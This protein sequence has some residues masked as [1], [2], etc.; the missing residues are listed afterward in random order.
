[1]AYKIVST[2][3]HITNAIIQFIA[4]ANPVTWVLLAITAAISA[5]VSAYTAYKL[6]E[7][8][9]IDGD[10]AKHFGN[11][12]LSME[13]IQNIA[14]YIVSS[15]SL[16]G[17]K[18]ALEAFED[19]D[20]LGS[21]M[22]DSIAKLD[23][24]N[25]KVSIG[26]QLTS[27]EQDEYK[28]TIDEYVSNAQEYVTQSRY[29]VSVSLQL[30]LDGSDPTSQSITD[31]V[32]K[33]YLDNYNQLVQLGKDL[34][35]AITDAFNDG[36]LEVD[37]ID[38]ITHLQQQMAN[39][40]KAIA[41]G[42]Y[43]AALA[44]IQNKYSGSNLD[45]ESFQN[46]QEELATQTADAKTAYEEAYKKNYAAVTASYKGGYLTEGEYKSA[47]ANL[48]TTLANDLAG[49]DL[50]AAQFQINS[51]MDN[52][53]TEIDTYTN[54]L[55]DTIAEFS[56]EQ[57]KY[58]WETQPAMMWDTVMN[59]VMENDSIS[60]ESRGAIEQ[61]LNNM[62]GTIERLNEYLTN[63]TLSADTKKAVEEAVA[64]L[65]VLQGYTARTGFFGTEGF[66]QG[67]SYD[68]GNMVLG[69]GGDAEN[70]MYKWVDE[71]F[72]KTSVYAHKRFVQ[73]G[74]TIN[75][76]LNITKPGVPYAST[77]ADGGLVR[78]MEL[79]WL[80]ERGPEMVVPL[81]GSRRAVS[82][83]QQAGQLLGMGGRFDNVSL[84]GDSA[85]AI[86]YSPTLQFYGDAP[87]RQELMMR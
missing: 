46:L 83:W 45:S 69:L 77:H 23:K 40:Q 25:W 6:E 33:F 59:A 34:N 24:M 75:P 2:I 68:L 32:D 5:V 60:D 65:N 28:A 47:V 8:E 74:V 15:D 63:P 14:S 36:L 57:Y 56:G 35:S 81:D 17:V 87:D 31:K 51:I 52:Y 76:N 48:D 11:I 37:E 13:D 78:S 49:V 20:E 10:L 66:I 39:I 61:L 43:D 54:V 86:T 79:S 62:S 27:D 73:E 12:K 38:T 42:E 44:L 3:V 82:L 55:K 84:G 67:L 80:A 16:G 58:Q 21:I 18:R 72:G 53:A 29:A 85:P 71:I 19:V 22:S 41:T 30:G 4:A 1:M 26:M 9:L 64:R 7:Q 50:R 70:A